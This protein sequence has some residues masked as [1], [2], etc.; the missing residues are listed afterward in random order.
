M[1]NSTK[2]TNLAPN[3]ADLVKRLKVLIAETKITG[4]KALS[5]KTLTSYWKIGEE[6][7]KVRDVT[8]IY[9]KD[10]AK[11]AE[12][13]YTLFKRCRKFYEVW[14]KGLSKN[15]EGLTWSQHIL[16]LKITD[17]KVRD[18]YVKQTLKQGWD[19]PSL[20]RAIKNDA[21][22]RVQ[23]GEALTAVPAKM[24]NSLFVYKAQILGYVDGD[25]L[26][27][28]IDLGF[29]M[30]IKIRI[31]LRG[32]NCGELEKNSG[33]ASLAARAK[34]FI[35]QKLSACEF[36]VIKTFK[37]DIY[38]RYLADLLYHPDFTT[39]DDVAEKGFCLNQELLKAKL[40]KPMLV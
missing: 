33:K 34:A 24:Q 26:D 19:K 5:Q 4:T 7:A 3:D 23:N 10:L 31:R 14:P 2:D 6:I 18:F 11:R 17:A 15:T 25:T 27:V 36:V 22:A 20:A 30:F 9:V 1:K 39:K 16:L 38:G 12:A 28:L 37:S 8:K 35:I 13:P 21:F 29:S 40:A 32:I